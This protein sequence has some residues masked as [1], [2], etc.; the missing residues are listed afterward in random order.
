MTLRKLNTNFGHGGATLAGGSAPGGF[1]LTT[2]STGQ[3]IILTF[4]KK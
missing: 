3:N 4:Y 2:N 1:K